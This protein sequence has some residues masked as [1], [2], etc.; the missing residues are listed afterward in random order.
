MARA[1]G[2]QG[3]NGAPSPQ[4]PD[5]TAPPYLSRGSCRAG[6]GCEAR[7]GGVQGADTS[8][9]TA[10][11]STSKK[12]SS[13]CH[14]HSPSLSLDPAFSLALS[15]LGL[16]SVL[17][18]TTPLFPQ[19]SQSLTLSPKAAPSLGRLWRVKENALTCHTLACM[20]RVAN[21]WPRLLSS[22]GVKGAS[23]CPA[24][25]TINCKCLQQSVLAISPQGLLILLHKNSKPNLSPLSFFGHN[26][27]HLSRS[28]SI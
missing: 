25:K 22:L 6:E 17:P 5:L 3:W 13:V 11:F 24:H 19:L 26:N 23:R 28:D 1:G 7:S 27:Q 14:Y 8:N 15:A 12:Q 21:P 4:V 9:S 20:P 10:D 16:L 18:G 2:E